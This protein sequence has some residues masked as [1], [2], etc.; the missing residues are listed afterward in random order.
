MRV[1]AWAFFALG[2]A[3]GSGQEIAADPSMAA[4][5]AP[6]GAPPELLGVELDHDELAAGALTP[7]VAHVAGTGLPLRLI[8]STHVPGYGWTSGPIEQDRADIGFA[9]GCYQDRPQHRVDWQFRVRDVYGRESNAIDR[10]VACTGQPIPEPPP[11]L[12]SLELEASALPAGG[13]TR[14]VARVMGAPP[15]Y[16]VAASTVPGYGWSSSPLEGAGPHDVSFAVGCYQDRPAHVV[17]WRFSARDRYGR[18]SA[19][20]ARPVSCAGP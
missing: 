4:H 8:A 9:I 18:E 14:G 3:C 10:P 11:V 7:G 1:F 2:A 12:L 17:D 13:L 19:A 16:L 6:P 15:V 20:I 5:V